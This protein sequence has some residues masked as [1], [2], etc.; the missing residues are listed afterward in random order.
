MELV[1]THC[2]LDHPSYQ[3]DFLKVLQSAQ[4]VGV[5][6]AIIPAASPKD[7]KRAIDLC[8][9]YQ[10]LYFAVGVH[11]LDLEEFDLNILR[12]HIT[13][14]KCVA[15]GECGLDYHRL[16]TP[17]QTIIA[18]QKETFITQIDLAL[19]FEKPLIVHI[20]EASEDAYLI[21]KQ[22]PKLK[23]VLHC[24]NAHPLLLK[25]SSQFY[26]G[27]GGVATFKNA[28]DLVAILPQIPLNRLLLET[29]APYLTP[30]PFRGQR[31][32]P[33]HIPLIAQKI[34]EVCCINLEDLAKTTTHNAKTLFGLPKV[35]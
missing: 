6:T 32:E 27:I 17:D 11:P 24:Y 5:Q 35:S 33:H 26:Y 13:H 23:G 7:L 2:H 25:L 20:R 16:E 8:E 14:P 31:N 4:E 29:D 15:V 12:E 34:A 21:L 30:H 3:A 28:K 9:T 10:N 19:E 22:Y 18:R 1:D